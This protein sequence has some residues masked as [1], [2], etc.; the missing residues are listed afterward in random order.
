M[1]SGVHFDAPPVLGMIVT[2]KRK[3]KA[4]T[5]SSGWEQRSGVNGK[6]TG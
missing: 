4:K 1:V 6:G 2:K 5:A 3:K